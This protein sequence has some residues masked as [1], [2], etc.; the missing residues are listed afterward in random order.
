M[1]SDLQTLGLIN[2]PYLSDQGIIHL[3]NGKVPTTYL[4]F[5]NASKIGDKGLEAISESLVHISH[6]VL[7]KCINIGDR[8]VIAIANKCSQL[9][10]I[11]FVN[12]IKITDAGVVALVKNCTRLQ[13]LVLDS[14]PITQTTVA[15]LAKS[16]GLA[17][18]Q[19]VSFVSCNHISR[20]RRNSRACARGR[21]VLI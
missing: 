9:Q 11:S 2:C 6:L 21:K 17:S 7:D 19:H 5:S 15:A 10:Y 16:G 20:H 4:T 18:L 14:V 13:H 1:V 3:A 12:C 8:G